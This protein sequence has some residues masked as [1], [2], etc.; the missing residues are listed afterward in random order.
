MSPAWRQVAIGGI[1]GADYY[2]TRKRIA[3]A[4]NLSPKFTPDRSLV[5][6]GRLF[7]AGFGMV[8]A[9]AALR[10]IAKGRTAKNG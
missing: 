2:D 7:M 10:P 1:F 3:K 9:S 4:R 8:Q 5:L 6:K